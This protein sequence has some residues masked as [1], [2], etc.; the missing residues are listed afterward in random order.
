MA[1]IKAAF[2]LLKMYPAMSA[3]LLNVGVMLAGYLGLHITPDQLVYYIGVSM[4]L[5]GAIVHSNVK[6]LAKIDPPK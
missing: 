5:F 2:G 1:K 4:V 6:P 3:A